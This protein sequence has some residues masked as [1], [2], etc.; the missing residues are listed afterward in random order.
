MFVS[1]NSFLIWNSDRNAGIF[2]QYDALATQ[3]AFQARIDRAVD[4]IFFFIGD[5]FQ[6]FFT[7][8]HIDMAGG[9]GA[10]PAAIVVQ[11]YVV[12]LSEFQNRHIQEITRHCFRGDAGIFELKCNCSH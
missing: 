10:N 8:F 6:E 4:E 3:P 9:T 1:D 7:A 12:L 5:F 2:F 11:V